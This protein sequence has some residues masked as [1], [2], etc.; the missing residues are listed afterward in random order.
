MAR[1]ALLPTPLAGHVTPTFAV[2]GEL[3]RR[4]EQVTFHLPERFRDAVEATGAALRP[5]R[6]P[7]PA[8]RG[9]DDPLLR[10]VQVPVALTRASLSVL[11]QLLD[12]LGDDPPDVVVYDELSIWG[13]I[14]A[15]LLERP[16]AMVST[17]YAMNERFSYLLPAMP[18][19][20]DGREIGRALDAFAA[21]M[22]VLAAT[23]GTPRINLPDLFLHS[24]PLTI[25]FVPRHWQPEADTFGDRHLFVGPSLRPRDE[26][27]D[28][29]LAAFLSEP[30]VFVSL[31][32]VF[33][34]WPEFYA[35]CRQALAG[36]RVLLSGPAAG[37]ADG[38]RDELV[39]AHV[40]QRA[41]LDRARVFVTHGGMNSVMEALSS[42]VPMLMVPRIPEQALTAERVV[43]AGAGLFL[44]QEEL[45]PAALRGAVERLATE[46]SY[47]RRA[48]A[49]WE[50]VSAGGGPPAAAAA[51]S[52]YARGGR[53]VP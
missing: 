45:T 53:A 34:D 20:T 30:A 23:Y 29:E 47:R 44:R 18:E 31:G 49:E 22:D 46:P 50:S 8:H 51:L 11:P 52:R 39:R 25:V 13:R 32:T 12:P 3:V 1:F 40:P 36:M 7:S 4:G 24:E 2:A 42:G 15:G 33:N 17:T 21:D 26:P 35:L 9:G 19:G 28:Q 27:L 41:V 37:T 10:L 5:L 14:V 16:A 38:T 43:A 6:V 48:L